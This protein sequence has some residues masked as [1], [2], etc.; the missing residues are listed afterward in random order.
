VLDVYAAREDPEPGVTGR[1]VADAVPGGTAR[2]VPDF[3]DVPAV[4][5]ALVQPGDLVLTMGAGDITKMGPLVLDEIAASGVT[6][7]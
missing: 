1:L 6:R 7:P 4:V 3:A 5:A 2:Y